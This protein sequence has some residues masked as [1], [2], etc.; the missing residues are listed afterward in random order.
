MNLNERE[1]KRANSPV[2]AMIGV[3]KP[4]KAEKEKNRKRVRKRDLYSVDTISHLVLL[5]K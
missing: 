4:E 3:N 2:S 5:L 1:Q